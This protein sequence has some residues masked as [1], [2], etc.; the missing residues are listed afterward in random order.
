[1]SSFKGFSKSEARK[2]HLLYL[3]KESARIHRSS[4]K[5]PIHDALFYLKCFDFDALSVYQALKR[6]HGAH[7]EFA[8]SECIYS[9][10]LE[11][12]RVCA[13]A[14]TGARPTVILIP[15]HHVVISSGEL[16]MFLG[17]LRKLSGDIFVYVL[18]LDPYTQKA[19]QKHKKK[20]S[21]TSTNVSEVI[22][23]VAKLRHF[24]RRKVDTIELIPVNEIS[25]KVRVVPAF[26]VSS[27][28][29][30]TIDGYLLS[31]GVFNFEYRG[32]NEQPV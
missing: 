7:V 9:P 17:A 12:P 2:T 4:S 25:F 23:P 26:N 19:A 8:P 32:K 3:V 18:K 20:K 29:E 28:M 11:L 27:N 13:T 22:H 24:E 31:H 5:T 6:I 14:K 30:I 1:L 10:K 15:G 21:R 16:C